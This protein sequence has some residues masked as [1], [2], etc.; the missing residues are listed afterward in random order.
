MLNK[1]EEAKSLKKI[2]AIIDPKN[3]A[4]KKILLKNNFISEKICEIDG[5]PGEILSRTI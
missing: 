3:I 1:S 2:I 5:L 4:S